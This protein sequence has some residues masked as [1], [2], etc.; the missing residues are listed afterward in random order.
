MEHTPIS[1][2]YSTKYE[3]W[4]QHILEVYNDVNAALSRVEGRKITGRT[5]V[6][7]GVVKMDYEGGV[8]ILINYTGSNYSFGSVNIP[9][10]SY[11][12]LEGE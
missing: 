6:S 9:A 10:Q 2:L 7:S 4:K 3:D 8:S 11:A 12:V 5:V 1:E